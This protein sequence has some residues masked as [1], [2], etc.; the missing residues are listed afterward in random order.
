MGFSVNF[1]LTA[2]VAWSFAGQILFICSGDANPTNEFF[3]QDEPHTLVRRGIF[4]K[5][6]QTSKINNRAIKTIL[7]DTM[8][9]QG[10]GDEPD[11]EIGSGL[12]NGSGD[13]P[14]GEIESGLVDGNDGE[15]GKEIESELVDGSGD[16]PDGEIESGLVDGSVDQPDGEIES[17]LVDGND[18]ESDEEIESGLVDGNGDKPDGE[19]EPG[20]QPKPE[21]TEQNS[22]LI[23]TIR[24]PPL[25]L[26]SIEVCGQRYYCPKGSRGPCPAN[27]ILVEENGSDNPAEAPSYC[28][29]Y[30]NYPWDGCLSKVSQETAS[31]SLSARCSLK[32]TAEPCTGYPPSYRYDPDTKTCRPAA[33]S[34]GDWLVYECGTDQV[35]IGLNRRMGSCQCMKEFHLIYTA[36]NKCYEPFTRGP[37]EKK[38][39]LVPSSRREANCRPSPCPEKQIDGKHFYWKGHFHGPAGCYKP[40][41]RGPCPERS[42]FIVTDYVLGH[43]RCERD[44]NFSI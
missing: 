8:I 15:P 2:V 25:E 12:F 42:T 36:E 34:K 43:S 9:D 33:S 20:F 5:K 7:D 14:D 31:S 22:A 1:L 26:V 16:E 27:E 17:G 19:S 28:S 23:P 4:Q 29:A 10:S 3:F 24:P 30:S 6:F 37:C 40:G 38:M 18:G 32:S 13:Q 44:W 21:T 35:Y 11:E 41:T 39:W